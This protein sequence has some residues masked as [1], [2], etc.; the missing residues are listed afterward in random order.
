MVNHKEFDRNFAKSQR[1]FN[2]M[3]RVIATIVALGF[4]GIVCFWIF[5]GVLAVKAA[6]QVGEQGVRGVVEQL[7]CGKS[8][9]CKLP[10]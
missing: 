10:R 7:W 5:A 9:D 4:V 3:F 8:V 6:D 1:N 2:I